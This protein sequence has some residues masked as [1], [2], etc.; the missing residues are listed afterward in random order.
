MLNPEQQAAVDHRD[1]QLLVVAGA[2][3]G[4]TRMLIHRLVS[5]LN[6]GVRPHEILMLTFS[7]SAASEM[8]S[9]AALL[10]KD[11]DLIFAGT[12]HAAALRLLRRYG[13]LADL[14]AF[15]IL[16]RGESESLL[17]HLKNALNLGRDFPKARKVSSLFS[18]SANMSRELADLIAADSRLAPHLGGLHQLYELYY[19]YKREHCLADYDDLLL[20]FDDL[21]SLPDARRAI[22]APLRHIL[23]DE[24]Q[25]TNPLQLSVLRKLAAEGAQVT[26]VGDDAQSIY[27][28]RGADSS[29]MRNFPEHFPGCRLLTLTTNYRSTQ[30]ILDLANAVMQDAADLH[31]KVLQSVIQGGV[32]PSLRILPTERKEGEYVASRIASLL[33]AGTPPDQIA[34]IYSSSVHALPLEMQ[35]NALRIP[36]IKRGGLKLTDAAHVKDLLAL[37]RLALSPDY[38][39]RRRLLML[40]PGVKEKTAEK[41]LAGQVPAKVIAAVE[42]LDD[43]IAAMQSSLSPGDACAAALVWYQP[44]LERL[45]ADHARRHAEL[46][47]VREQIASASSLRKALD[48]FSLDGHAK[49]EDGKGKVTLSTVHW[50]KGREFPQVFV[51]GL[52]EGRF[53]STKRG[54]AG[55]EEDRRK[56]YVAL[57]RAKERLELTAPRSYLGPD[58]A[59]RTAGLSSL[60]AGVSSKVLPVSY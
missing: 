1:S 25:D 49:E 5:L 48:A 8:R 3:T 55:Y 46:E 41:I 47:Q 21:L 34:V 50:A 60:L 7:N 31:P 18:A 28:F 52:A 56:L 12:Y 58:F 4:K 39:S 17:T 33:A 20:H 19:C 23:V 26:A 9:R 37:L 10:V 53:S 14:P 6:D 54:T 44:H 51:I 29:I 59:P 11:A 57:T 45:Y 2:G 30:P 38:H 36:Y 42:S 40:L 16:D 32:R 22:C 13:R 27:A 24:F 35:L 15:E 43:C